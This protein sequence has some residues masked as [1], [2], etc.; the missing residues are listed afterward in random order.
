MATVKQVRAKM[1]CVSVAPTGDTF[2][3]RLSP[4]VGGSEENERFYKYTPGGTVSL[5]VLNEETAAHFEP[6]KE[7]YVDF[8]KAK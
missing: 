8:S 1:V 7:Y 6:E 3:V 4:V 2:T 5:E